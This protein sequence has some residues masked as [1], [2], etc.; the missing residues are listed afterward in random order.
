[1]R[2]QGERG[3]A[4]IKKRTRRAL[5]VWTIVADRSKTEPIIYTAMHAVSSP[6]LTYCCS[7]TPTIMF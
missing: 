1:M 2:R 6:A 4:L 7:F 5:P 3:F